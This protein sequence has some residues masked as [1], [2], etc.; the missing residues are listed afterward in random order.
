MEDERIP[1]R[2]WPYRILFVW[3][4]LFFLATTL[5]AAPLRTWQIDFKDP[6]EAARW[7]VFPP[8]AAS[9]IRWETVLASDTDPDARVVLQVFAHGGI[10]GKSFVLYREFPPEFRPA[11]RDSIV[12]D[13]EWRI[14]DT[15]ASGSVSFGII[16]DPKITWRSNINASSFSSHS[17]YTGGWHVFFDPSNEWV[18][19]Q[20][21]FR[22]YPYETSGRPLGVALGFLEPVEQIIHIA[23]VRVEEWPEEELAPDPIF[24]PHPFPPPKEP[25]QEVPFNSLRRA[26]AGALTDLDGDL[27]PELLVLER[28]GYAHL[29]LND[30]M[31]RFRD[32]VTRRSG[33]DFAT[34]GMGALFL[35]LDA[36]RDPDLVTTSE[37]DVPRFFENIGGMR[38]E[39]RRIVDEEH[40]N[41]WYSAAAD[42]VDRDGDPDLLMV[43]PLH[44]GGR[45]MLL[46]EGNWEFSESPPVSMP[47]W[48]YGS[49]FSVAFADVDGD[50][51]SDAFIAPAYH[52]R[53]LSGEFRPETMLQ[54][55]WTPGET[56]GGLFADLNG[57]GAVDFLLLRDIRETSRD[58]VRLYV[59]DGGSLQEV[60][61]A[62]VDLPEMHEAEVVLAEDFDNDGDLDLYVC[63][64]SRPN[65]LLLN[66]DGTGF[67]DATDGSGFADA[68]RCDAALAGDVDGDGGMDVVIL[69]FGGSP[70][71]LRNN[72]ERGNWVSILASGRE[73]G[74]DAIGARVTAFDPD[75]GEPIQARWVRR[76]RGFGPTGPPEL[77]FGLGER[78]LVNLEVAF[79]GGRTRHITSVSS[80]TTLLVRED[81][82]GL[83]DGFANRIVERRFPLMLSVRRKLNAHPLFS[84][85]IAVVAL[86]LG[87]ILGARRRVRLAA[88]LLL[89]MGLFAAMVPGSAP[90][91][92]LRGSVPLLWLAGGLAGCVSV[93]AV[94]GGWRLASR[95]RQAQESQPIP[96]EDVVRYTHDFRHAGLETRVLL[97]IHGRVKNL[98]LSGRLHRP[99]VEKIREHGKHYS[100]KTAP[101]LRQLVALVRAAFPDL[102]VLERLGMLIDQVESDLSALPSGEARE[103]SLEKWQRMFLPR[104]EELREAIPALLDE[105][106]RRC[107]CD[108]EF[109]LE[110][111]CRIHADACRGKGISVSLETSGKPLAALMTRVDLLTILENLFT[112]AR[113][114]LE[115]SQEKQITISARREEK[116]VVV[117]FKDTGPG[118]PPGVES[119]I[120]QYG[121]S[122]RRGGKGYGLPRSREIMGHYDGSITLAERREGKGAVFVLVMRAVDGAK[123]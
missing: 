1:R 34:L 91:R 83:I 101:R 11:T 40:L 89:A 120:F 54:P 48:E 93:L 28:H 118:V 15:E 35:D 21:S 56:E 8:E 43:A 105:L 45:L 63:Q 44:I 38:F 72:L 97:S 26:A 64:N 95:L 106:D 17:R 67:S 73:P 55:G 12:L 96:V 65:H 5:N 57:D 29:Y 122:T 3:L 2:P 102:E 23:S 107:S 33:L 76:G 51:W 113:S 19:H 68:G 24:S 75:T 100:E 20:N 25:F 47:G 117:E 74:T 99:F 18:R 77:H 87:M 121:F 66:D 16:F 42:D 103:A 123:E 90:G 30:G 110:E 60:Q 82:G 6:D 114:V 119:K 32:D 10:E 37:F 9:Q 109:V 104:L 46:N 70:R 61:R 22:G 58:S 53:N 14:A 108:I 92:G 78:T 59:N 112:N 84:Y 13:W 36:D 79:P 94:R 111:A 98:F 7:R 4:T 69:R 88:A 80:G 86:L 49:T 85:A 52:Y 39:E 27:L 41:F 71:I 116:Q 115:D 62:E 81:A 31:G 50:G